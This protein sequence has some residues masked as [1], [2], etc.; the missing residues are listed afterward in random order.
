MQFVHALRAVKP[1]NRLQWASE[2]WSQYRAL[3]KRWS[4]FLENAGKLDGLELDC[5][6]WPKAVLKAHMAFKH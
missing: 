5:V 3:N 2:L 4:R 6:S 1:S